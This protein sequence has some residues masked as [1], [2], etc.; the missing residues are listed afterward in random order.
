MAH[1]HM[2]LLVW[3]ALKQLN[4]G[5]NKNMAGTHDN[6]KVLVKTILTYALTILLHKN[7]D[8]NTRKSEEECDRWLS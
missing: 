6:D 8:R 2:L 7:R 1:V 3:H 5:K 4:V